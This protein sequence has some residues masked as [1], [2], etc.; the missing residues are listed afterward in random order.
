MAKKFDLKAF[1]DSI[2]NLIVRALIQGLIE[3]LSGLSEP[4]ANNVLKNV[5]KAAK[6]KRENVV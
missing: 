4:D 6:A 1:L 5:A 2:T 3:W